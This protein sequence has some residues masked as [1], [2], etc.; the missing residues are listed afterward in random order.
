MGFWPET[1]DTCL[2][3]TG[4]APGGRMPIPMPP[5]AKFA[6]TKGLFRTSLDNLLQKSNAERP[7]FVSCHWS[8]AVATKQ[9]GERETRD[10]G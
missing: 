9:A 5:A 2:G 10:E 4:S 8:L 3:G 7:S 6:F 1:P